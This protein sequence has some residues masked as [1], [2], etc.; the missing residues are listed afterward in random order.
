[1]RKGLLIASIIVA[2]CWSIGEANAAETHERD[3]PAR[4]GASGACLACRCGGN[5]DTYPVSLPPHV[6]CEAGCAA[7]GIICTHDLQR[8]GRLPEIR[9]VHVTPKA[10]KPFDYSCG[11]GVSSG[12]PRIVGNLPDKA[13]GIAPRPTHPPH[14][15]GF[16]PRRNCV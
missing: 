3:R 5:P 13:C 10:G 1:M 9:K 16:G 11:P 4:V 12:D 15:C 8:P 2:A 14:P 7:W 6:Q